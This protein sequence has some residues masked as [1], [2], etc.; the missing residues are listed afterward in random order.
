MNLYA[1]ILEMQRSAKN[2]Q[3]FMQQE[4][5]RKYRQLTS[6]KTYT[7][8]Y[9]IQWNDQYEDRELKVYADSPEEAIEKAKKIAHRGKHFEVTNI[10]E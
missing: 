10:T 1:Q 8:D 5:N 2:I 7:I 6:G 4:F 3:P 9:W